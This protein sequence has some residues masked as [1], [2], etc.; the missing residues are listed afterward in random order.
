MA[1]IEARLEHKLLLR[2]RFKVLTPMIT[3][4]AMY[5]SLLLANSPSPHCVLPF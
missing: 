1:A 3:F 4:V 2:E 5:V